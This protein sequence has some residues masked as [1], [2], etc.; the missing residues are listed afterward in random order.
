LVQNTA[1]SQSIAIPGNSTTTTQTSKIFF[2]AIE[3]HFQAVKLN[4]SNQHEPTHDKLGKADQL[5]HGD[6]KAI[7]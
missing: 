7:M 5:H 1:C 2:S 3:T 4:V 6:S